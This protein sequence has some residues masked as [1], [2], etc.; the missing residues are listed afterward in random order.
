MDFKNIM[1]LDDLYDKIGE[2]LD[3]ANTMCGGDFDVND[4]YDAIDALT[5][6]IDEKG[7]SKEITSLIDEIA[8]TMEYIDEIEAEEF[9]DDEDD[10]YDDDDMML[11][12][13]KK[14]IKITES[15]LKIISKKVLREDMKSQFY[16]KQKKELLT[17]LKKEF[18]PY[19]GYLC[20]LKNK[21]DH[22][23][24]Y[25]IENNELD[26]FLR[27]LFE[28]LFRQPVEVGFDSNN[29]V[30]ESKLPNTKNKDL[31][32]E[33]DCKWEKFDYDINGNLIYK[34]NS[35]GEWEK[36]DEPIAESR[37]YFRNRRKR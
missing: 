5:D 25:L 22:V 3:K 11:E 30:V 19:N 24:E 34:E 21:Y 29:L 14:V 28:N 33:R 7:A 17:K 9:Y 37:R 26:D 23:Y 31:Y 12:S 15:D 13:K 16:N 18:F 36:F 2:L 10:D 1:D 8:E 6:L 4:P 35:D 32:V 20:T 27:V